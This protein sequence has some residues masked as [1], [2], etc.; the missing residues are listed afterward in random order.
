MADDATSPVTD[1]HV[2]TAL[3]SHDLAEAEV[4]TAAPRDS[5]EPAER[6]GNFRT[7]E[8]PRQPARRSRR[9]LEKQEQA[10]P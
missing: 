3:A 8:R 7:A 9:S 10:E 4:G 1:G 6:S 5:M 2:A